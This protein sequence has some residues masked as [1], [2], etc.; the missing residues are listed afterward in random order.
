M[1]AFPDD[2]DDRDQPTPER[3]W[4]HSLHEPTEVAQ[5]IAQRYRDT[6]ATPEQAAIDLRRLIRYRLAVKTTALRRLGHLDLLF[7]LVIAHPDT[8]LTY[9]AY[10]REQQQRASQGEDH[11]TAKT[12]SE[13]YGGWDGAL[14]VAERFRD[15]GGQARVKYSHKPAR[16]RQQSYQPLEIR[17]A[18]LKCRQH[19]GDWPTE[20]EYERWGHLAR[21]A[22]PKARV[23]WMIAV[24][25]AYG[26]YADALRITRATFESRHDLNS[27]Q[28]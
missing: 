7:Q 24:R 8:V 25:K 4:A 21:V 22:N 17:R 27:G 5:V 15:L 26:S 10:E 16:V 2:P 28:P 23:P 20:Y 1:L 9:E 12:L 14:T 6:A 19:V 3:A 13:H 18:I 11:P